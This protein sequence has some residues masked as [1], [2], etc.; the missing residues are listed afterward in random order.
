MTVA[1]VLKLEEFR[2][3]RVIRQAR[4]RAFVAHDAMRG[5][6]FEHLVE[7]AEVSG[8]DRA[9]I[10]WI[11]EYGPG[12]VHPHLVVD[13]IA[14]R[15]RRTFSVDAL[16][17]A[18]E[19]G[20]PGTFDD[21]SAP[22]GNEAGTFAVAL[23]SDGARGWF[24]VVDSVGRRR[25]LDEWTRH[26][27]MF[28][29]GECSALVLHRDLD[30]AEEP[31]DGPAFD[32]WQIL[33]DL[34]GFESD[35]DRRDEVQARFIVGRLI[36][37]FVGE[38]LIVGE[39]QRVEQVRAARDEVLA[40]P[41]R[42]EEEGRRF[43]GA[44]DAYEAGDV[45]ALIDE[46]LALGHLAERREHVFGALELYDCAFSLA[47]ALGSVDPAIQA[48]R[49]SGRTLRRH[50]RWEDADAWYGVALEIARSAGLHG[51]AARSLAGLGLVRRERGSFPDART[52]FQEALTLAESAGERE[53]LA[54][55]HHDLMGL[56][57]LSGDLQ[58]ALRHGWQ[59]VSRYESEDGR[60]RCMAGMAGVLQELGDFEAAEDAHLLVLSSTDEVYYRVY[61][62]DGLAYLAALRGDAEGFDRWSDRCDATGWERGSLAAKAEILCYRGMG[63]AA[64]GRGRTAR[65]WLERAVAFAEE[66]GFTRALFRAEDALAALDRM[67]R[68][69]PEPN[70][71]APDEVRAGLR[72]MRVAA[73][74]V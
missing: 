20:I 35:A 34:E 33:R 41:S 52:H 32:G 60:T 69:T 55:I 53:A 72:A 46:T 45:D 43:D 36:R 37:H 40:T 10:V 4:A 9:A 6:L 27:L 39:A 67:P 28:L 73:A 42:N 17:R 24:V 38:D 23:G 63:H 59:A 26:R 56:E 71:S 68:E 22:G 1:N 18:W 8:S 48:A 74:G 11:D 15:P 29:T 12:L 3:R 13:A 66:H 31:A 2:D 70:A 14:D 30:P 49:A 62:L 7:I 25:P 50:A 54:S 5:R 21:A 61:A 65:D 19:R 64:L 57:Q 51:L 47:S 44:L 16:H 58:A